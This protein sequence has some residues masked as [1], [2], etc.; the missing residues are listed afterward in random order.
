MEICWSL[1]LLVNRYVKKRHKQKRRIKKKN[2]N[3]ET[4]KTLI[5][6]CWICF[7]TLNRIDVDNGHNQQNTRGKP[8]KS[9][10]AVYKPARHLLIADELNDNQTRPS[11][12]SL[13]Q[14]ES[15]LTAASRCSEDKIQKTAYWAVDEIA[16]RSSKTNFICKRIFLLNRIA[17]AKP[18]NEV[19]LQMLPINKQLS[20]LEFVASYLELP[21]RRQLLI[22]KI[23]P[24]Q[25]GL[26]MNLIQ[27][28]E[29]W[30]TDLLCIL[31]DL[32]EATTVSHNNKQRWLGFSTIQGFHWDNLCSHKTNKWT[33]SLRGMLHLDQVQQLS[34]WLRHRME[35]MSLD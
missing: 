35:I 19:A 15:T 6:V 20:L 2:R 9:I 30:S 10:T 31:T 22:F 7:L 5:E 13:H 24:F 34:F 3:F 25:A 32:C 14:T 28:F 11:V 1:T 16:F 27:V 23:P 12:S 8:S 21:F 17:A 26:S 33:F 4:D 18:L 29:M